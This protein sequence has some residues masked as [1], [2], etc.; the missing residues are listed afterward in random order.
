MSRGRMR[1]VVIVLAAVVALGAVYAGMTSGFFAGMIATVGRQARKDGIRPGFVGMVRYGQWRLICVPGPAPGVAT[2]TVKPEASK[3]ATNRNAC[4]LNQEV[5]AEDQP[6][7]IVVAANLSLVGPLRKPALMLRLPGKFHAGDAVSLRLGAETIATAV[8]DC[9][10]DE[11]VAAS[12]LSDQAW[13]HLVAAKTMQVVFPV[14]GGQ[15]A[16]IA[17]SVDGLVE[18][19]AALELAETIP[20]R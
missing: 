5:S 13:N 12:A 19:A 15:S 18:A 10:A 8:R 4:R 2:T 3:E 14:A 9:A 16:F 20:A 6:N 11:C 1:V 7:H 17:L